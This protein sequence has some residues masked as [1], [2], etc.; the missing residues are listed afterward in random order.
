MRKYENIKTL[1][2]QLND[3]GIPNR[4]SL[5]LVSAPIG[6]A[7]ISVRN[8]TDKHGKKNDVLMLINGYRIPSN[9]PFVDQ[10]TFYETF[11][12]QGPDYKLS[13]SSFYADAGTGIAST[14]P[15]AIYDVYNA[16][17]ELKGVE[18]IKVIFDNVNMT[19]KIRCYKLKHN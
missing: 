15:F 8:M 1:Y 2:Y 13:A 5:D 18:K 9:K 10:A 14:V 19:R 12:I 3:N 4:A 7:S 6:L 16:S 11:I 17:G